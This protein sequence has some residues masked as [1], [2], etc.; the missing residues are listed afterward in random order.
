MKTSLEEFFSLIRLIF[1]CCAS[2]CCA[3]I[4][5]GS[6]ERCADSIAKSNVILAEGI[7][8]GSFLLA[9]GVAQGSVILSQGIENQ[10]VRGVEKV[11]ELQ[12]KQMGET[13]QRLAPPGK[14]DE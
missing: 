2:L 3:S 10:D 13:L 5:A 14:A 6:A 9:Q 1:A 11:F 12:E 4:L 8:Q 7:A